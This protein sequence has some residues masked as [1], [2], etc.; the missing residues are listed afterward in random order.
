MAPARRRL[1][2]RRMHTTV[3]PRPAHPHSVHMPPHPGPLQCNFLLPP[4]SEGGADPPPGQD[5]VCAQGLLRA[6]CPCQKIRSFIDRS[7]V[8]CPYYDPLCVQAA[9]A[10][11]P[12]LG[13]KCMQGGGGLDS[14][15]DASP[16]GVNAQ[17]C[18]CYVQPWPAKRHTPTK[19]V[20][21]TVLGLFVAPG[22]C[23]LG[24]SA[25]PLY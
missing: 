3:Q 6:A 7:H 4:P 17:R 25:L 15:D 20:C 12:N 22:R 8:R 13:H 21:N 18:D 16:A 2:P 11:R 9:R 23:F 1:R 10:L 19:C 14:R 24:G 5:W